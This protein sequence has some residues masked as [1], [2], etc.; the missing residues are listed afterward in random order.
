MSLNSSWSQSNLALYYLREI[1]RDM[2]C[3]SEMV[4]FTTREPILQCAEEIYRHKA[5]VLCLSAYIWNRVMLQALLKVLA[6]LL[7]QAVF[8][9]GGPES[10]AFANQPRTFV[11]QGPGE[12]AFAALAES[13]FSTLAANPPYIPLQDV[14]FP[15]RDEDLK[16]L[17]DHLLYYECYRGCP[18]GC[19]YCL[20]ANDSRRECRFDM[21]QEPQRQALKRELDA[22]VA[23]KPRTIKFIDRSFNI[24][25]RLA[26]FIWEYAMSDPGPADFHFE[27]YPDLIT[28]DDLN[29]LAKAPEGK[30]RFEIGIQT[31]D[32]EVAARCGRKS[33]W[34]KSREV[35]Q[36]LKAAGRIRVHA[37]LLAGLP[38]ENYSSV[39]ASLDE[40][41]ACE[42]AAVQL[43]MLKILPDTPMRDIAKT[44]QYRWMEDPPYQILCSNA[45]SYEE[46]CR[47]DDYAHL[48]SLYWNK[49]EYKAEWH[50]LLS[51]HKAS[52]ILQRLRVIHQELGMPLHSVAKEKRQ[53]VM[54]LLLERD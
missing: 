8:V 54:S 7:P 21:D 16:D 3:R 22:L 9:V 37:D 4:V 25:K 24:N 15:Y 13:G 51:A 31:I 5:D 47:L 2:P 34:A 46:L 14:P 50:Q 45:L 38:G 26:H 20:S 44:L 49:E 11:I 18:Y 41:C 33:D 39:L 27:I 10:A 6:Q 29:L 35:L 43:G 36:N 52:E 42:P 23:L 40:L 32:A 48:L 1:I 12:G 53:R 17:E 19:I 30:I 28:D